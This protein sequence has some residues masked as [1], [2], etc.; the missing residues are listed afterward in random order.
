MTL[1]GFA[2]FV[3][4]FCS[5]LLM[6]GLTMGS[7]A[8]DSSSLC[9]LIGLGVYFCGPPFAGVLLAI[10]SVLGYMTTSSPGL[11]YAPC[12]REAGPFDVPLIMPTFQ[13]LALLLAASSPVISTAIMVV[14]FTLQVVPYVER[15][16][17]TCSTALRL[18]QCHI[19]Y[20]A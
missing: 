18:G 3:A 8:K 14:I 12:F 16:W 7:K 9:I 17:A 20:A 11:D 5:P 6:L 10:C 4:P 19:K 2:G 13:A 15:A 1:A